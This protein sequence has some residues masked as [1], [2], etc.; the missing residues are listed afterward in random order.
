M[1]QIKR[2]VIIVSTTVRIIIIILRP[3]IAVLINWKM[4]KM[5]MR[6]D[7]IS[8]HPHYITIIILSNAFS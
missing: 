6:V 3:A 7:V 2:R 8:L 5:M 4:G 1:I